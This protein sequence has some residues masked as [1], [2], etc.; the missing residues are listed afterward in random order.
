MEHTN[1]SHRS[2]GCPGS[3]V[4]AIRAEAQDN[5]P[6]APGKGGFPPSAMAGPNQACAG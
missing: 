4:T 1:H 2:G 6:S 3:R 5:L